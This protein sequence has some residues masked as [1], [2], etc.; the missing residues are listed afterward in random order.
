MVVLHLLL[1][2]QGISIMVS[3]RYWHTWWPPWHTSCS[4]HCGK[5]SN[6]PSLSNLLRC[7]SSL[8]RSLLYSW[9]IVCLSIS[10]H[11]LHSC[12]SQNLTLSLLNLRPWLYL[13]SYGIVWSSLSRSSSSSTYSSTYSSNSS[14]ISST[15]ATTSSC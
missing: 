4:K 2:L 8:W 13:S 15:S 14:S 11:L 6:W 1:N 5:W 7:I 12:S 9:S 10:H 3:K